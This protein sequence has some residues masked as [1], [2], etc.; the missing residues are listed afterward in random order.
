MLRRNQARGL[1]LLVAHIS[2]KSCDGVFVGAVQ[3][4][5]KGESGF[6]AFAQ[7][8]LQVIVDPVLVF[9]AHG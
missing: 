3:H 5:V 9:V 1:L 7:R 4:A 2:T 8:R 6:A